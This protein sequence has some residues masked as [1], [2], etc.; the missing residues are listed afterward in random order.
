MRTCL[1]ISVII[2]AAI[3]LWLVLAPG[4][5]TFGPANAEPIMVDLLPPQDV[6]PEA[7]R[8]QPKSEEAKSEEA[9]SEEAKSEEVKTE[10]PKAGLPRPA[11][12]KPE[13]LKPEPLKPGSEAN[14]KPA[15]QRNSKTAAEDSAEERAATAAR[16]AWML[17]LPTDTATSLAAPPSENK[18][19]LAGDEIA[20]FKAQVSKCWIAPAG[21]PN[22][23]GF[24]VLIR[25]ALNP[26]GTLGAKPEL[27]RAPASLAGPPLVESAKRALQKCQPYA[28]LPAD[29]Y[30]D[31]KILDL[32]FTAQGPSGLS[33]PSAGK[34]SAP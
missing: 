1:V 21:V 32:S 26:D 30:Q 7:K 16:L 5:K 20:E 15:P 13:P 33:G 3:M 25:I 14:Q 34:S 27:I 6:P 17:N 4:A 24:D 29:K 31:W 28:A 11:P 12:R 23:P 9:K 18:S 19:N 8:E 22:T 10:G 2:H